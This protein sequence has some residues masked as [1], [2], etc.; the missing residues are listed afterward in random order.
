VNQNLKALKDHRPFDERANILGLPNYHKIQSRVSKE[1]FELRIVEHSVQNPNDIVHFFF[2][3]K[4]NL[5]GCL[6]VK[7]GIGDHKKAAILDGGSQTSL[8][9]K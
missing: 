4:N 5:Q 9:T 3:N 6:R 8:I 2:I 1:N 7:V